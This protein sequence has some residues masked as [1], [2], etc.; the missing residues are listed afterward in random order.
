MNAANRRRLA[1]RTG[2]LLAMVFCFGWIAASAG[3]CV[4]TGGGSGNDNGNMNGGNT[5]DNGDNGNAGNDNAANDNTANDNSSNDN[6]NANDNSGDNANSNGNGNANGDDDSNGNDNGTP[7]D[8]GLLSTSQR[9]A[10]QSQCAQNVLE[11]TTI[12]PEAVAALDLSRR[13]PDQG[14]GVLGNNGEFTVTGS[15]GNGRFVVTGTDGDG[16]EP[17]PLRGDMSVVGNEATTL[18]YSWSHAATDADKCTLVPGPVFSTD[19]NPLQRMEVG[20]HYIRLTVTNDN[21]RDITSDECGLIAESSGLFDFVEFEIE[22]R[23]Q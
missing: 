11:C 18:T 2:V 21:I 16:S 22:V 17:I 4:G 14:F 10:F 8:P 6:T 15:D 9:T 13:G 20:F 12:W 23:E 1:E 3:G 7:T 5:N 19:P